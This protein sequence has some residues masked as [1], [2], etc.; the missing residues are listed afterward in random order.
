M[1]PTTHV[2]RIPI[3][4]KSIAISRVGAS[5]VAPVRSEPPKQHK[6]K[7]D[8]QDN[9]EGADAAVTITVTVT[10]EVATEAAEQENDEDYKEKGSERHCFYSFCRTELSRYF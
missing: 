5:G 4:R 10:A 1:A 7:N 2:I 3:K 9:A 6:N 8:D